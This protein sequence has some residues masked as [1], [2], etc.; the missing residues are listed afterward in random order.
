MLLDAMGA[1]NEGPAQLLISTGKVE[2]SGVLVA[3][4]DSGPGT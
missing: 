1:P 4:Q 2:T 3:V